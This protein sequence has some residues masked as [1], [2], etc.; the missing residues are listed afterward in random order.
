MPSLRDKLGSGSRHQPRDPGSPAA[1]DALSNH[2]RT[3]KKKKKKCVYLCVS[4][5]EEARPVRPRKQPRLDADW[6]N[7]SQ[8]RSWRHTGCKDTQKGANTQNRKRRTHKHKHDD[9]T[10]KQQAALRKASAAFSARRLKAGGVGSEDRRISLGLKP[11]DFH[12]LS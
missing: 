11:K 7:L 12:L 10:Q 6:S 9:D 2:C 5:R 1:D 8:R 4:S 3:D